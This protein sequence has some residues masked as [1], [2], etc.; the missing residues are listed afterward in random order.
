MCMPDTPLTVSPIK[1]FIDPTL[2]PRELPPY[3]PAKCREP[4]NAGFDLRVCDMANASGALEP[5]E[6]P[7]INEYPRESSV[8]IENDGG[9]MENAPFYMLRLNTSYLFNSGVKME[10]PQGYVGDVTLRSS[11][12]LPKNSIKIAAV[13]EVDSNYRGH[14]FVSIFLLGFSHLYTPG[15][16]FLQKYARIGQVVV[17]PYWKWHTLVEKEDELSA[18]DRGTKGFGQH[19][20]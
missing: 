5:I 16:I 6:V 12:F 2:Y 19:T 20:A 7:S 3:F 17:K 8:V 9:D 11:A 14:V 15:A 13:G 4:E 1:F 18:T 10:I